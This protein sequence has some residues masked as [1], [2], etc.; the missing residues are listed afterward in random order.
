MKKAGALTLLVISPTRELALQ[1]SKDATTMMAKFPA[2]NIGI[3]IGGTNIKS[4]QNAIARGLS[5]LVA[6][7]GRLLDH[8][9]QQGSLLSRVDTL[10]L[11]E[12]DR[13]LDMGFGPGESIT[14]H[15]RW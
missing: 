4:E 2:V 6:T 12:C 1:I 13:L 10:V 3:A 9:S 5:V 8:I 7:P 11:D 15:H 14:P